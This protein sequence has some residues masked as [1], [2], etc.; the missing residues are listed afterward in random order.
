MPN[1]LVIDS[2]SAVASQLRDDLVALGANVH[3]TGDGSEGLEHARSNVPDLIVLCVELTRGSGYSVCNKLKK[4]P[5]LATIPLVLTSSQATEETF[6]QHKKLRTRA[7]DYLKKPFSFDEIVVLIQKHV[8]IRV[9]G[10]GDLGAEAPFEVESG[11][12]EVELSADDLSVEID[13]AGSESERAPSDAQSSDLTAVERISASDSSGLREENR[14]LRQKIQK[15]ERDLQDKAVE[16]NDRLLEESSRAREGL[17]AKRRLNDLQREV[18]KHKQACSRSED[19]AKQHQERATQLQAKVDELQSSHDGLVQRI[20]QVSEQS[21]TIEIERDALLRKLEQMQNDR[22]GA[23]QSE[24]VT[25]KV[26]EKAKKA[27]DIALQL[28][29]ETGLA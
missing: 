9:D 21:K 1:I 6:E 10:D 18:E 12:D 7:E 20:E 25:R 3:V 17:D 29:N 13:S 24:E 16:F 5:Q 27:V 19:S 14:E 28:I 15:L 2:E 26:K 4:D 11:F 8:D 22:N 23:Q